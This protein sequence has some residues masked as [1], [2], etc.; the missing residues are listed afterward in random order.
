[1]V[2]SVVESPG[3]PQIVNTRHSIPFLF[4]DV[5]SHHTQL[6]G[7]HQC[8]NVTSADLGYLSL[9]QSKML[10]Q[11]PHKYEQCNTVLHRIVGAVLQPISTRSLY[12]RKVILHPQNHISAGGFVNNL[13]CVLCETMS[14]LMLAVLLSSLQSPWPLRTGPPHTSTTHPKV[15]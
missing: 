3:Q 6:L 15:Y 1:M 8:N 2:Y 9:L 14:L 7:H 10:G 4:S 12:S 11:W 5:S 13:V